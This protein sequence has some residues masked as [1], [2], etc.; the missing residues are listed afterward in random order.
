M[1]VA[2]SASKAA[3]KAAI[4][5]LSSLTARPNSRHSGSN[6]GAAFFQST[7]RAAVAQGVLAH[8]GHKGIGTPLRGRH[9]LAV[10]VGV[11]EHGAFGLRRH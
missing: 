3:K 4:E 7:S 1:R 9:R 10:V 6:G 2:L 8:H 11:E 5:A